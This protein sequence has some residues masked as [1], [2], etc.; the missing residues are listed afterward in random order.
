M[1]KKRLTTWNVTKYVRGKDIEGA[2][3]EI[4]NQRQKRNSTPETVQINGKTLDTS[5]VKRSLRR[6]DLRQ[7]K[8]AP[9][10]QSRLNSS[11]SLTRT[12]L[13]ST[14]SKHASAESLV[15]SRN[16]ATEE[17]CPQNFQ[18]ISGYEGIDMV[19][20][21]ETMPY[22]DDL[23]AEELS[24]LGVAILQTDFFLT[25][26][27]RLA[28]Q[29]EKDRIP[30]GILRLGTRQDR[31]S[32]RNGSLLGF[33]LVESHELRSLRKIL[34]QSRKNHDWL[35]TTHD[36]QLGQTYDLSCRERTGARDLYGRYW[37]LFNLDY[38]KPDRPYYR[39]PVWQQMRKSVNAVIREHHP[40]FLPW[41][42][43]VMCFPC[44]WIE[45]PEHS[46]YYDVL[47]HRDERARK[48]SLRLVL[49]SSANQM[50]KD[51]P[52]L[53]I[54]MVLMHSPFKREIALRLLRQMIDRFRAETQD[55][56]LESL[57]LL[58]Q[59]FDTIDK[60]E[61]FSEEQIE[62]TLRMWAKSS[63]DIAEIISLER[64]G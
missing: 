18:A 25:E 14:P 40:H 5:K 7:P 56:H 26:R 35:P 45:R 8:H 51:D 28:A 17:L 36:Q 34:E 61:D 30:D 23:S 60:F 47:R 11:N 63:L 9:N 12:S 52:R 49:F 1:L 10:R 48:V 41:I 59:F 53:I 46:D 27:A 29:K 2:M 55:K 44:R 6:H 13:L 19:E 57:Q 24:T 62:E 22:Q 33:N 37:I 54:Q 32:Q 31:S 38:F 64:L 50:A 3:A 21:A 58:A 43:F 15:S 39:P 4:S 20:A 16:N 42:C